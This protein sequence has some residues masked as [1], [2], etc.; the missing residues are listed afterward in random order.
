MVMDN[1]V[2]I[3]EGGKW[4]EV[5]E[6]IEGIK[7]DLKNPWIEPYIWVYYAFFLH[8]DTYVKV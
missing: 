8:V 7:G 6:G 5:E 3:A 1:S 4:M 2:V